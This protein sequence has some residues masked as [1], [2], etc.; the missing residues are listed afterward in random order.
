MTGEDWESWI[1]A[2]R[3]FAKYRH[4]SG[5]HVLGERDCV[6]AGPK[7]I[8]ISS[9]DQARLKELGWHISPNTHGFARYT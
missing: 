5:G 8:E 1:E 4:L 2:F 3:I 7:A 9:E 6:F